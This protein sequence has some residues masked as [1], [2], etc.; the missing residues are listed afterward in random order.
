MLTVQG[1]TKG[2]GGV[3][4]VDA[5]SFRVEQGQI[6]GLIGPNGAGKTTLFNVIS[7]F[8]QPE[9]G[10]VLFLGRSIVPLPPHQ[11]AA[12]GIA[13][14][15]QHVQLFP[16]VT[17]LENV[18]VGAH[19]H[20]RESMIGGILKTRR[21]RREE[22]H[23]EARARQALA[24]VGIADL[25]SALPRNLSY[26][27]Q[28]CVEVA[29]AL[30]AEPRLLLLDEVAAG[31]NDA[32]TEELGRL[33]GSLRGQGMT[34]LLVEHYMPL[35]MSVCENVVVLD[36]GKKI[37][38]GSPDQIRANPSVIEAYLGTSSERS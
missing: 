10:D 23:L 22:A 33:I 5:V 35:V 1:V 15:F 20:G 17:V 37:A 7:G 27:L 19:Q 34:V 29:R 36:F 12:L 8:L 25:W 13:R 24:R 28:K 2:F 16:Q 18:M 21:E 9:A 32:E 38:E 3:R 31:L 4:A 14:T 11:R 26:G 6:C 30:A